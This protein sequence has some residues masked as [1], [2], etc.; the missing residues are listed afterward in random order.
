MFAA[1]RASAADIARRSVM[2]I[3]GGALLIVAVS[4]FTSAAWYWLFLWLGPVAASL[5]IGGFYLLVGA[6]L[7]LLAREPHQPSAELREQSAP[8]MQRVMTAFFDGVE[9]G[10]RSRRPPPPPARRPAG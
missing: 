8:P 6:V 1:L 3:V 10:S 4:F 9:A 5:W 2:G 7:L